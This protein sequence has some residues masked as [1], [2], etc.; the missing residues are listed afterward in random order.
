[1]SEPLPEYR[2][3]ARNTSVGSENG[4]HD[5]SVA[6]RYGFP[7]A[8]VPGVT[9]YA[10]LTH[11]LVQGLGVG[12]LERGSISVRFRRPLLDGDEV[13]VSGEITERDARGVSAV[14]KAMTERA[15]ECAVATV[16]L[17]A[18]LPTPVNPALYRE[19]PLPAERPPVSRERLQSVAVLGTPV[20]P[21]D[22]ARGTE[23]AE[24]VSDPLAVY[25]GATGYVHPA[26]YLQQ[27]NRVLSQNVQLGPWIHVGSVVRH[28][29]AARIGDT[30]RALGNVRSLYDKKDRQYVELDVVIIAGERRAVA[31]VLH[32][33]IYR[34]PL[35]A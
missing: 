13:V 14:V 16:S 29:G 28:L 8:L 7:G 19:A 26:F 22:E 18:G 24:T 32:T 25:R 10:Y 4:I 34:L 1:V 17:P 21:Y 20:A 9:V 2:V 5:D 15:G 12:W 35:P 23:Y 3:K 31:H 6:R 11:P 30:L 33:A 27:A